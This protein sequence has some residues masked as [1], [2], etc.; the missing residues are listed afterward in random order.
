MIRLRNSTKAVALAAAFVLLACRP[1]PRPHTVVMAWEAFPLSFDPRMGNDQASERL[2]ALTHQGLLR[3]DAD[4]R[5]VPDGCLAWRWVAPYTDLAFDFPKPRQEP[6]AW[7]RFPSGRFLR[8]EDALWSVKSL[9]DPSVHG[10]KASVFQA[11]IA[12]AWLEGTTLRLR[13]TAADP[14]FPSNLI[15]GGMALVP[16]GARGDGPPGTGPYRILSRVP[17]QEILLEARRDHPDFKDRG[18][19]QNLDLRLMPDATARLL[20]LRHGSVQLA[21]SNVPPDLAAAAGPGVVIRTVRGASKEYVAFRCTDPALKDAR[22]RKALS[23]ALDRELMVRTLRKGWARPAWR[24]FPPRT[25]EATPLPDLVTRRAEAGRLLD[26]A[27]FTGH[28]RL[29]LTLLTTPEVEARTKAL[30]IQDQWRKIGVEVRLETKEFGALFSDVVAGRFQVVSLRWT[31]VTDPAILRRIF[32]SSSVPPAGFNRGRYS[33]PDTDRLL[34]AADSVAPAA[35]ATLLDQ[36]QDRIADQ[37]PYAMLWWPDQIIASAPGVQV[38]L[39]GAGDFSA[40]WRDNQ[41]P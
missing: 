34:E 28:P 30:A 38:D 8:A 40:V 18:E 29:T 26:E 6:P 5:L 37:A 14:G 17:E 31:G 33:D 15:R 7:F 27:G 41:A 2:V 25:G 23:L 35:R 11:K 20:A 39:N 12:S 1:H 16:D 3:R 36:A 4:L 24:F 9:M 10:A 13:L 32:H 21:L 19:P 22:V